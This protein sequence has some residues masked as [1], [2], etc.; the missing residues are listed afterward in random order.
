MGKKPRYEK[1][2][3]SQI[4]VNIDPTIVKLLFVV[5]TGLVG[6]VNALSFIILKRI[7]KDINKLQSRTDIDHD[8]II[9]LETELQN[10][11][12]PNSNRQVATWQEKKKTKKHWAN[13]WGLLKSC[14]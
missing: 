13:F 3:M 4:P 6:L 11:K 8:K 9:K 14:R 7:K 1:Y 12:V 5:I 2:V 10:I